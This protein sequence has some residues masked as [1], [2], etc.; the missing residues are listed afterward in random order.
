METDIKKEV[1]LDEYHKKLE[2][3]RRNLQPVADLRE[4][5]FNDVALLV[6]KLHPT[7]REESKAITRKLLVFLAEQEVAT[8]EEMIR[9]LGISYPALLDRLKVLRTMNLVRRESR[10]F[11]L[12]TP[13]L[14]EF[15]QKYMQ[16]LGG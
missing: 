15:V 10:M 5:T 16:H 7:N 12:A 3:W 11:Y 4:L 14:Y 9:E 1:I 13:R 2:N 8:T 6:L